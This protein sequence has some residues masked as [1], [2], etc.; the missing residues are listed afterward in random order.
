MA[1]HYE[2]WDESDMQDDIDNGVCGIPASMVDE[3]M[4]QG[5]KPWEDDA[6]DV[7][8]VLYGDSDY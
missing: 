6:W 7:L 4:C 2:D 5:V 8:G 3:L 1:K